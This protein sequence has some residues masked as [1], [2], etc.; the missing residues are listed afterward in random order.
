MTTYEVANPDDHTPSSPAKVAGSTLSLPRP[1]PGRP[2]TARVAGSTLSLPR[3]QPG[4]Q[5]VP[6]YRELDIN[7]SAPPAI[8]SLEER[9]PLLARLAQAVERAVAGGA[10][11]TKS[12]FQ[13]VLA[14]VGLGIVGLIA[15]RFFED[16]VEVNLLPF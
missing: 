8:K 1:Q 13:R 9:K 7:G 6:F 5:G 12:T 4:R 2:S 14:V 11:D 3:P 15:L 10:Q 16:M